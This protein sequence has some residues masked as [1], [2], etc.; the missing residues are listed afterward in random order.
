MTRVLNNISF[1]PGET[2]LSNGNKLKI[3]IENS[4]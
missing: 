4:F 3:T 1:N 2:I